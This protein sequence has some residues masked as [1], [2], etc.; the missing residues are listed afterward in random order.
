[1]KPIKKKKKHKGGKKMKKVEAIIRREKLGEVMAALEAIQIPGMMIWDIEGYGKQKGITEQFRGR[2][3]NVKL[4][5]KARIEIV[6]P[7]FKVN[8]VVSAILKTAGT[9]S[10]GDG[11][12]FISEIEEA[13]KIR[14]GE[15]GE[16]VVS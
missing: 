15:S 12:I 2:E 10:V 16:E 6:L 14:T 1:M 13:I 3:F 4:M 8:E 9:G 11:K 5:P 7:A